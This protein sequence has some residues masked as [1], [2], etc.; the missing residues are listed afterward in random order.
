M[1]N[2]REI[3]TGTGYKHSKE[4]VLETIIKTNQK[5]VPLIIDHSKTCM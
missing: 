5:I 3:N 4:T 1:I 2:R